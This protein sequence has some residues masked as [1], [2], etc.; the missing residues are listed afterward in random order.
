MIVKE[1][2]FVAFSYFKEDEMAKVDW[3]TASENMSN[4]IF[5]EQIMIEKEVFATYQPKYILGQTQNL[6]FIIH[7]GLQEWHN[8]QI[9]PVW[10]EIGLQKLAI[11]V[12]EDIFAEVSVSQLIED[13][14][15]STYQTQYFPNEE[16]AMKWLNI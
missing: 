14:T 9:M 6:R 1:T 15:E 5:K 12:S 8:E 2:E 11:I 16:E 7:P 3:Q 13:D 10:K 4:D